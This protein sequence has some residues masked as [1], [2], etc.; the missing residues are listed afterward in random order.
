MSIVNPPP[1]PIFMHEDP[2]I[3]KQHY[4]QM[5]PSSGVTYTAVDLKP[6]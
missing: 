6:R 5:M 4:R 1:P 2:E 3:V